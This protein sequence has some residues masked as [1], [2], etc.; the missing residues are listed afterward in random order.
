MLQ[1]ILQGLEITGYTDKGAL[2]LDVIS[3]ADLRG[4][5]RHVGE[6]SEGILESLEVMTAEGKQRSRK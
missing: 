3:N 5:V 2:R 1:T 6:K 4:R